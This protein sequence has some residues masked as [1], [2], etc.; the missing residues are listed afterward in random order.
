MPN[1]KPA[2]SVAEFKSK[3]GGALPEDGELLARHL[4]D[5]GLILGLDTEAVGDRAGQDSPE[6]AAQELGC[7]HRCHRD[8]LIE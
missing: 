7:V 3:N 6:Q 8:Y 2:K 1:S 4:I 5:A